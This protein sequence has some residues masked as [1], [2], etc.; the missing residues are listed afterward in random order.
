MYFAFELFSFGII[1]PS[2]YFPFVQLSIWTIV[3]WTIF[4]RTI[5]FELFE[6]GMHDLKLML[7]I[8]EKSEIPKYIIYVYMVIRYLIW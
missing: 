1:F 5:F 7:C 8:F 3:H 2:N 4:F 6:W